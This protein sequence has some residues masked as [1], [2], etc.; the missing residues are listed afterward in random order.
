MNFDTHVCE[1][2]KETYPDDRGHLSVLIEDK[3]LGLSLKESFS[4]KNV[5]RGMHIQRPPFSQLKH[6]QVVSGIILDFILV[7]DVDSPDFGKTFTKR[8]EAGSSTYVIPR[9][10]AHGFLAL[11]QLVIR[12]LCMGKYSEV[13]EL[14]IQGSL[15]EVGQIIF[16]EKDSLAI[17]TSKAL[18]VFKTIKW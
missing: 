12:Y 4:K 15:P 7:L 2:S 6:I 13:D 3:A 1:Y 17:P 14:A 5:F 9:Y 16:S 10:C 8:I 18:D 11:D